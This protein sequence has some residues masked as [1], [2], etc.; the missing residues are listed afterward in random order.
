MASDDLIDLEPAVAD[1]EAEAVAGLTAARKTLPCKLFYD[2]RG[3][4]LF[5]AICELPEYYLTRVEASIL[6]TSMDEIVAHIGPQVQ[7]I[8][9]GSG[10]GTKT[11]L[12]L[13]ALEDPVSY[14][15]I[16]ISKEHLRDVAA[17]I[18]ADYPDL[19]VQAVC[20]D[21]SQAIPAPPTSRP[22]RRRI[23]FFPGST[24]GNFEA[25]D[26]RAFLGRMADLAGPGG[27]L[28]IGFDR[29]KDPAVLEAAY[30]DSAGVTAEFNTNAL[31]RLN[32][33]AGADFALEHFEHLA[34]WNP[35][36]QRIEMHLRS[37]VDQVV[38][39]GAHE[40]TFAAGETIHTECCHKYGPEGVAG[41]TDRFDVVATWTD[42]EERF[43]I[44][45]LEVRA[46]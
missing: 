9:P 18:R 32:A 25:D 8:E 27:G 17:R 12:L 28:L 42:P 38:H 19:E 44:Q 30:D 3:A 6:R 37:L 13:S 40:I 41:L 46:P 14:V 15:P 43:G 1:L 10:A 21:F 4:E 31:H 29:A 11:R 45:F 34:R 35:E 26:A 23:V 5:E 33:E 22:A 24:I 36:Y 2:Q 39:L 20:A 16:D 7:L